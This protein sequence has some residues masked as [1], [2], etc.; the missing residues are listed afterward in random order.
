MILYITIKTIG[1]VIS[2]LQQFEVKCNTCRMT[3]MI[4]SDI[5]SDRKNCK[6]LLN[7][8]M[9]GSYGNV[10]LTLGWWWLICLTLT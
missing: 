1:L 9:T 7:V 6:D 3:E 10:T 8:D 5:Y 4:G 2:F